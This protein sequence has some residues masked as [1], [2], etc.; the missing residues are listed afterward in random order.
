MA[1]FGARS[2]IWR[3]TSLQGAERLADGAVDFVFIDARHD[4]ASVLEDLGAW[5]PKVRSGGILSGHDYVTGR[6]PQGDFGVRRAVDQFFGERGIA[7]FTTQPRPPTD[8]F[9]TWLVQVP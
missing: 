8:P 3:L 7:V 4:Y 2:E 6:F 9:P 1:P 5:F